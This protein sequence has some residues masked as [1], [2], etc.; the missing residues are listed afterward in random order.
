[1]E[2]LFLDKITSSQCYDLL[3]EIPSGDESEVEIPELFQ[4]EGEDLEEQI[5]LDIDTPEESSHSDSEPEETANDVKFGMEEFSDED[6]IP[7]A[8]M[9]NQLN[10]DKWKKVEF[11]KIQASFQE[12]VGPKNL[13]NGLKDPVDFFLLLFDMTDAIVFQTN[14][15]SNQKGDHFSSTNCDEIKKFIA[16]NM[17]MG[18][19]QMPSYR[20]CWSSYPQLRDEYISNIMSLNRFSSLLSHLHLN[21]NSITPVKGQQHY[22]KLYK[23]RPFINKLRKNYQKYYGPSMEQAVDET[24]VKFKGRISFKQYLP[25]KPIKRG[26]KIWSRADISGYLCDFEVYTGKDGDRVQE[27]LGATVVKKLTETLTGKNY[28]VYFD[29][30]FTSVKLLEELAERNIYSCGTVRANRKGLPQLLQDKELS[31]GQ[32]DWA[33]N[34]RN[35]SCVKWKDK[36]VVQILS[37]IHNPSK[38]IQVNRREKD[39]TLKEVYCPEP[40]K[41][42][43]RCMGCVDRADM[44]KSCYEIDRKSKKWWH[45]LF[46]HFVD[47]TV[48]N[49]YILYRS[50][51]NAEKLTMKFFRLRIISGLIGV[52]KKNTPGKKSVPRENRFKPYVPPEV[53]KSN[54]VH[55][56]VHGGSRRCALCSTASQPHRTK[57]ACNTCNVGLCLNAEKNCFLTYHST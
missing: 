53:R 41:E 44:L 55:M 2:R 36:R 48:V 14:L 51:P 49:S 21:D 15:Y 25:L 26:F 31:R 29:N 47:V 28:H 46:W 35:I 4:I 16:I 39:G 23:I 5:L 38:N 6:D 54:A 52:T 45:R 56:P 34:G 40:I 20:D 8:V 57:W 32:S 13:P 18:I 24:M 22:D 33:V 27:N 43:R 10:L 19:K 1:M 17:L 50:S 30:Y 7:L 12:V 3:D 42:Y 9:A 37:S 11:K